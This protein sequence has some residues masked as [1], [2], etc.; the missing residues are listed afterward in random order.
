[1]KKILSCLV[2]VI[3]IFITF[4][5]KSTYCLSHENINFIYNEKVFT[6]ELN[7]NMKKPILFYSSTQTNNLKRFGTK[8]ERQDLLKKM[9]NLNF[10]YEIAINYLF[11]NIDKQVEKIAKTIY[12]KP[13]NAKIK[14]NSNTEK[15]FTITK[16]IV[17]KSLDKEK[18]Y[19]QISM[20]LLEN[21]D[22][23]IKIP[24]IETYPHIDAKF[25]T[26]QTN[27]RADFSTNIASSSTD[28][29]HNIKT[30]INSLNKVKIAPQQVF[31]FNNTVGKRTQENGYRQAKIIVNNEFIDGVGGGVCQVSSTLYNCALLAGLDIVEANKHS[32]QVAYVKQGFDAMVNFGSSDLKFKNNTNETLTIITNFNQDKIRIR[33]FGEKSNYEYKLKNE[34]FNIVEPVELVEIDKNN[35]YLDK[36]E[37]ED[38]YFYLKYPSKGMEIKTF[39][40]KYLNN[41]IISTETL[42]HDKY[43][44]QNAIKVYGTKKRTDESVRFFNISKTYLQN[45]FIL[46][47]SLVKYNLQIL[48][49]MKQFYMLPTIHLEHKL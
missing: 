16:E 47:D 40:E 48:Y 10:D 14:T 27:L 5:I 1:M 39:R 2:C 38:E 26:N 17:G 3:F 7:K 41:Q 8:Q 32:K 31:S 12:I 29:K 24:I 42:R 46:F 22:L 36:V 13:Q 49:N 37:F 6:Y 45:S 9:L 28:R 15:V 34:I 35:E 4:P 25:Y 21:K 19:R 20:N 11:P 18:L 30:A 33:I 44:V 43:K 23:N